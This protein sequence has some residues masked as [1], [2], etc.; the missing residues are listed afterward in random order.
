[1]D[2]NDQNP[3]PTPTPT[4][5]PEPAQP[6]AAPATEER[7]QSFAE[8]EAEM[9]GKPTPAPKQAPATT[10]AGDPPADPTATTNPDEGKPAKPERPFKR[11]L[12]ANA[13]TAA[14][15]AALEAENA[16]LR[17]LANPAPV[18]PQAP[19]NPAPAQDS[20]V[21]Q[22]GPKMQ[23]MPED[24]EKDGVFDPKAYMAAFGA[25]NRAEALRE[26]DRREA[27][28]TKTNQAT[29]EQ[30]RIQQ[31]AQTWQAQATE[32]A[33]QDP[34]IGEALSFMQRDEVARFIPERVQVQL[35][36]ASPMVAVAIA[37]R[38]DLLDVMQSGD[39]EASLRLIGKI[40]GVFEMVKGQ[41]AHG[42]A[43]ELQQQAAPVQAP[44]A[45]NGQF[46][47]A[48]VPAANPAPRGPMD[49]G[50]GGSAAVHA[51]DM[52]FS[53]YEKYMDQQNGR[54]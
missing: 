29:E 20:P 11:I 47:P 19:A 42:G 17:A 22:Y 52:D 16:R 1:M 21:D 23:P 28:R 14:Q 34:E 12:A 45:P 48:P 37:S 35:L 32:L 51:I 41:G 27:E 50:G 26:V 30:G 7:E 15:I 43:G 39:V 31:A 9:E 53:T 40:E 33:Q 13:Q 49:L 10:A 24:F 25:W 18:Q 38:Q 5:P 46:A 8:Y 36:H 54:R 44:R 4:T 2:H 6:A 3:A